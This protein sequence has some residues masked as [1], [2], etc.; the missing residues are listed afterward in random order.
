MNIIIPLC[1][2][3]ERFSKKGFKE[4]KALIKVYGKEIIRHVIDS[5]KL[6]SEDKLYVIINDR[7]ESTGIT[8]YLHDTTIINIHKETSGASETI[9]HGLT[10]LTGPTLL[11]DGDNF[12]RTDILQE[13]RKNLDVNQVIYFETDGTEA[14]VFSYIKTIDGYITSIKEKEKISRL[15]NSGAYFFSSAEELHKYANKVLSAK[16]SVLLEPDTNSSIWHSAKQNVL[17]EPY[18]SCII[19]TMLQDNKVFK[20]TQIPIQQYFS[21]GTPEQ[22]EQYIKNTHIFLFDLD[23]TLVHSDN[24]YYKI[25]KDILE[26]YKIYINEDIYKTYIYSNSDDAVK[27]KLLP[28]INVTVEEL[29]KKKFEYFIKYINEVTTL[30]GADTFL[31]KLYTNAHRIAIVTNSN[32]AIAE[33]VIKQ[34]GFDKYVDFIISGEECE[35]GKP[36]SDPYLK[37][38]SNYNTTPNKCTIFEDSFNGLLSA[39]GVNPICIVGIG[40]NKDTLLS[41]GAHIVYE[42]YND[43]T[44][45]NV[46]ISHTKNIN[47][48]KDIIRCLQYRYPTVSNIKIDPIQLKGGFIADVI[49]FTFDVDS[50]TYRAVMKIEN[51]NESSLN[52][53]ANFLQLY[54]REYYFY[55]SIAPYVPIHIPNCYGI[56]RDSSM[57]R[58]GI[59]LEDLRCSDVELNL[60]LNTEPISTS[61]TLISHM[62]KLHSTFWNKL[63]GTFSLLKKHND[64][65]FQPTWSNFL[66]ERIDH[67]TDKWK[68]ILGDKNIELA[69]NITSRFNT[70]QNE[71]SSGHLTLCHG[72]IKSPNTFYKGSSKIPYFIDWQYISHGKGVQ[73]L[74]FFMIESFTP[75]KIK[76]LFPI[77][78]HYYYVQLIDNGIKDYSYEDYEKDFINASYYFPFFVA[79]WFGTVSTDDLIDLNFPYF[80]IQ[81]L[82]NFYNL[83]IS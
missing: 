60:N 43:I 41:A 29:G 58:V 35:N 14:P 6:T 57:K 39:R 78:K 15:A 20:A 44:I 24:I 51:E 25:W 19:D 66:N 38:I 71:L 52:K 74:V 3:G 50:I 4:T 10:D 83:I 11:V 33:N 36:S 48:T 59:L 73:D 42:N 5:L 23:G 40:L 81:R 1:G 16:H 26:D 12:Y 31:E 32:K 70:I 28:N 7:V 80:Y 53:M 30:Q 75:D 61:F 72:D 45:E 62:T 68:F 63:D 55:E 34:V 9:V 77:F 69:K 79:V 17:I 46:T 22:V 64:S 82:F 27:L 18:I 8:K 37:A 65:V 49:G 21:L 76:L 2:R 47:Y 13:I 67:F 56:V 54:D